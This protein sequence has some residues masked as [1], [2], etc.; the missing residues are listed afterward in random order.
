MREMKEAEIHPHHPT[1]YHTHP[2][3]PS[4]VY[5]EAQAVHFHHTFLVSRAI[6][7]VPGLDVTTY[8]L[9]QLSS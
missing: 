5:K 4:P 2:I 7:F 3:F 1:P 9:L 8:W 6:V